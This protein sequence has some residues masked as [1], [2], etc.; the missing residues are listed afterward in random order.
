MWLMVGLSSSET[1]ELGTSVLKL[2][3]G[4]RPPLTFFFFFFK[5]LLSS[6]EG[7]PQHGSLFHRRNKGEEPERECEQDKNHS[8]L[9]YNLES[10]ISSLL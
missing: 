5:S 3:V 6:P 8:V 1:V 4:W 2:S 9:E 7:S 10:G